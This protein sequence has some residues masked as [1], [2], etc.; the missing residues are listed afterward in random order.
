[1]GYVVVPDIPPPYAPLTLIA[2]AV[3]VADT[4]SADQA[5]YNCPGVIVYVNPG[6]IAGDAGTITVTIQGKDPVAGT[7]STIL[8]SATLVSSTAVVLRVYPGLTAAGNL[9]ANAV[10]PATWRINAAAS[11]ANWGTGGSTLGVTALLLQ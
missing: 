8:A 9:V 4:H 1:V 10:L 2:S 11:G 7:Y 3:L 5:S 6:V